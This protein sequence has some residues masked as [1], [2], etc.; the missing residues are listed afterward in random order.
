M[1]AIPSLQKEETQIALL[2][3]S[4]D[5][6][7]LGASFVADS[8]AR[9]VLIVLQCLLALILIAL[10][11]PSRPQN[12]KRKLHLVKAGFPLPLKAMNFL[13]SEQ[14]LLALA[15][16][17]ADAVAIGASCLMDSVPYTALFFVQVFLMLTLILLKLSF[18]PQKSE[19]TLHLVKANFPAP[20]CKS[21]FAAR[22][23]LRL[24]QH[25][26]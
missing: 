3:M 12:P 16:I 18:T 24:V 8:A 11:G 6:V 20:G 14:S 4:V 17:S 10:R 13:K 21:A 7:A 1:K 26:R 9:F 5:I 22:P 23:N 19:S 15:L 25:S 2:F